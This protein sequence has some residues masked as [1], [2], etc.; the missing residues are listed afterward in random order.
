[1]RIVSNESFRFDSLH[2]DPVLSVLTHLQQ[3]NFSIK[4]DN[5][6]IFGLKNSFKI[7]LCID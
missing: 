3:K 5:F 6:I 1:M 4:Y 2:F 7:N